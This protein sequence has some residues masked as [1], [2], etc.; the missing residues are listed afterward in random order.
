MSDTPEKKGPAKPRREDV[1]SPDAI[2]NAFYDTISGPAGPRNWYRE[3]SLY[4]EGARLIPI[5]NRVHKEGELQIMTVDQWIEDAKGYLEENDFYEA[6]IVRKTHAYGNLL[7]A[8]S[9]YE[10]RK[11]PKGAPIARGINSIQLLK[12]GGRWWIVNVM[13]DNESRSNPIPEEFLPY[14]W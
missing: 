14:L 8:F 10:T 4:L 13:W 9:T 12:K 11:D 6:E 5:G 2:I 7:Q 1:S 3:R